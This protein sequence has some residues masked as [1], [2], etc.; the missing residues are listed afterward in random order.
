[1]VFNDFNID[2]LLLDF[3]KGKQ[4][5]KDLNVYEYSMFDIII[6]RILTTRNDVKHLELP[7]ESKKLDLSDDFQQSIRYLTHPKEKYTKTY[8]D[9]E[10]LQLR[11]ELQEIGKIDSH[12]LHPFKV[13]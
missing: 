7:D 11:K 13:F 10:N 5:I 6:K 4:R 8:L 12:F 3:F 1:M 9:N 2:D